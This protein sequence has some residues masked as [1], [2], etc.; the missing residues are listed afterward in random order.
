MNGIKYMTT[1]SLLALSF[2]LGAQIQQDTPSRGEYVFPLETIWETDAAGD[3]LLGSITN[4]WIADDGRVYGYDRK[5]L[6]YYIFNSDGTLLKAF[7]KKGEGPGEIRRI[8]QAP[9]YLVNKNMIIL[10]TGKL[11]YFDH[12]GNYLKSVLFIQQGRPNLF[13]SEDECILSP[14]SIFDIPQG[15]GTISRINVITK[16]KKA[17]KTFD[18][19]KGGAISNRNIQAAMVISTLTPLMILNTSKDRI[20]YGMSDEYRIDICDFSGKDLGFFGLKRNKNKISDE[21]KVRQILNF[22]KTIKAQIPDELL[23]SLALKLPSQETY[24]YQMA[25]HNNLIYLYNSH[26]ERGHIQKIDLFSLDGKYLYRAR[27]ALEKGLN[28]KSGP[29]FKGDFLYL[30]LENEDGDILLGKYR[31]RLPR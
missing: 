22:S 14:R 19:Y 1:V 12:M 2:L 4:I 20:Y 24:F 7:G 16:E 6:K 18:I 31:T 10:D 23:R 26:F 3:M 25:I 8:E 5:N 21:V 29:V 17:I 15:K 13:L 27:V 30:A 28:I 9:L 11:H